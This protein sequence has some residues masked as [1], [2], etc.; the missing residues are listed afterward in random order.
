MARGELWY[1][2]RKFGY[3]NYTTCINK[4]DLNQ[5]EKNIVEIFKEEGYNYI[6]K[7]PLPQN[8]EP[9]IKKLLSSPWEMMSNLWVIGLTTGSYKWTVLKTSVPE[10]FCRQA[11]Y[12][13]CLRLSKLAKKLKCDIFHHSVTDREWGVL[14]EAN[15]LGQTLASGYLESDYLEYMQF[16]TREIEEPKGDKNFSL[17]NVP[18]K[19]QRAGKVSSIISEQEKQKREEELEVLYQS[20][21]KEIRDKARSEWKQLNMS[22]FERTDEDLGKLICSSDSFW[23]ENNLLYKAYAEPEQLE[24]DGVR[25]LFFQ[26]GRF[27]LNPETEE[28]WSPITSK[29]DYGIEQDIPF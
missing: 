2:F 28:I 6:S 16:Y 21:K 7:P 4:N 15:A 26:V 3:C 1:E 24:K 11:K 5:I 22:W 13:K 17:I 27:D 10:I 8:Q 14:V 18:K 29:K 20:D 19:F 9:L 23:H 25:L 12:T